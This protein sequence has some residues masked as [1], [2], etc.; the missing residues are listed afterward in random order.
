VAKSKSSKGLPLIVSGLTPGKTYT[1]TVTAFNR[2]GAGAPSPR[3]A[4]VKA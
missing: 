4:G 2:R 3:S 1:C